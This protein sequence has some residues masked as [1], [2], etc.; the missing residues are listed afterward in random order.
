MGANLNQRLFSAA[1]SLRSKMDASEYKNYL[2]GF[3][4]Y[5]YLSDKLLQ[6][7]VELADESLEKYDTQE[8][9]TTLYKDLFADD[10]TRDDLKNTLVDT[11][12]YDIEA[13]LFIQRFG[14]ASQTK[15]FQLTDLNKAF[16]FIDQLQPIQRVVR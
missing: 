1:D 2:L 5:K 9:Q 6:K 7:V 12:S 3:I 14:R 8:K 11:L 4:F 10:D 16:I 13:G 15:S